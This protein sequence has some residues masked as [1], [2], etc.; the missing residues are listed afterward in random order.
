MHDLDNMYTSLILHI[1]Y[2]VYLML[3]G[4][5]ISGGTASKIVLTPE[6]LIKISIYLKNKTEN[7]EN[8]VELYS[9]VHVY[10]TSLK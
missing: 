5:S 1:R 6:I 2:T 10:T 9:T 3:P 8:L 7:D 4:R